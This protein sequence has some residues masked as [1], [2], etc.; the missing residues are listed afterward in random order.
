MAAFTP[1]TC[2][3]Q[4]SPRTPSGSPCGPWLPSGHS[5][6]Q[7]SS[8]GWGRTW[9]ESQGSRVRLS[10]FSSQAVSAAGGQGC[11]QIFTPQMP[12]VSQTPSPALA[13]DNLLSPRQRQGSGVTQPRA[14]SQEAARTSCSARG[15]RQSDHKDKCMTSRCIPRTMRWVVK[16]MPSWTLLHPL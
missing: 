14:H 10:S 13:C 16:A 12:G 3:G 4:L 9:G 15:R 5:A 1:C 7:S 8:V 2:P 6:G 11:E